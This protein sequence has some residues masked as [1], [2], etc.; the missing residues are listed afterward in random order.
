MKEL[1]PATPTAADHQ[2]PGVVAVRTPT[3]VLHLLTPG[4]T[5]PPLPVFTLPL[6]CC[7]D[8]DQAPA[9]RAYDG[10]FNGPKTCRTCLRVWRGDPAPQHALPEE[11]P[12]TE[13]IEPAVR[14]IPVPRE[15]RGRPLVWDAWEPQLVLSHYSAACETCQDPGPGVTAAGRGSRPPGR[16]VAFRCPAC[17]HMTVYEHRGV[18]HL[19]LIYEY[20]PR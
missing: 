11:L 5:P 14:R 12:G 9:V 10:P 3:G 17:Q 15:H 20:R 1:A 2:D 4:T 19:D 18:W 13:P 6:L 16:Y 8:P 7:T